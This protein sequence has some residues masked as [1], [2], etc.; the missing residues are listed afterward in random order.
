MCLTKIMKWKNRRRS[1]PCPLQ[2]R[3]IRKN[4]FGITE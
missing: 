2:G 1:L 4:R 3:G